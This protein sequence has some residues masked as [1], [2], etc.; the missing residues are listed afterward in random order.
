MLHS[1]FLSRTW[2]FMRWRSPTSLL[3]ISSCSSS[4]WVPRILLEERLKGQVAT[5][6]GKEWGWGSRGITLNYFLFFQLWFKSKT[7][8]VRKM[9]WKWAF[10]CINCSSSRTQVPE[11]LFYKLLD[12]YSV[13]LVKKWGLV[14]LLCFHKGHKKAVKDSESIPWTSQIFEE[15]QEIKKCRES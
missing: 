6:R 7:K 1:F 8:T 4:T 13:H 9:F 3:I 5:A 11:T 15:T 10:I 14:S 2:V 12:R